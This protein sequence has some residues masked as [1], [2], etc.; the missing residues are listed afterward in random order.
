MSMYPSFMLAA[1]MPHRRQFVAG[2]KFLIFFI[3]FCIVAW[4]KLDPD[5]GWHLE[6]GRYILVHG[7]PSHDIFTYT[8]RSF[9]WINHE[10][11]NDV[12]TA[13][14]YALGGYNL[15]V[16][17]HSLLWTGALFLSGWRTRFA[18]LLVAA[19]AL[20]P[21]SGVR[22]ISWTVFLLAVLLYLLRQR[23]VLPWVFPLLFLVWANLHGGFV[24]GL[25]VLLYVAV[26]ERRPKLFVALAAS[27]AASFINPYGPRLYV[28]IARTLFD[29]A[30]HQQISE[31]AAFS[32]GPPTFVFLLLWLPGNL[33]YARWPLRKWLRPSIILF[34]GAL[35]AARNI[36]LFIIG[37]VQEADDYATRTLRAVP[38]N[39]GTF[40]RWVFG[41]V[42]FFL[43][44][45]ALIYSVDTL[46]WP[47]GTAADREVWY[48]VKAAAYLQ[49]HPCSG[50]LF[51]DYNYGGYLIWKLPGHPVYI[52]GRMPSW[53]NADGE[54]YLDHY[55]AI[56]KNPRLYPAEFQKYHITCAIL[57]MPKDAALV[58]ALQKGGWQTYVKEGSSVLLLNGK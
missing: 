4:R 10:W 47:L 44:A 34:I 2:G 24:I 9:P 16:A 35:S 13:L 20:F 41:S 45:L 36:P 54:K 7:I 58:T 37:S 12:I 15:L 33:L 46:F 14:I 51:N 50:N 53:R 28:E 19:V 52:D 29:P 56:I 23:H 1:R 26:Y 6:S 39:L 31:W 40:H 32:L 57:Q 5:F 17:A 27:I 48:P 49:R 43:P 11:G 42:L 18:V 8:A 21:F 22:A 38:A 55:D 3:L 30:L 25:A